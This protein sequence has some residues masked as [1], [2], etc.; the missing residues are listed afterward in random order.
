[1]YHNEHFSPCQKILFTKPKTVFLGILLPHFKI[2]CIAFSTVD[3]IYVPPFAKDIFPVESLKSRVFFFA[4]YYDANISPM[5]KVQITVYGT[6]FFNMLLVHSFHLAICIHICLIPPFTLKYFH[7]ISLS[8]EDPLSVSHFTVEVAAHN[9]ANSCG[10]T[11]TKH[12]QPT[13]VRA[14]RTGS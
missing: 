9:G 4:K 6:S 12:F 7:F 11:I 1:M 5:K 3:P 10:T 8:T 13:S 14:K 2:I